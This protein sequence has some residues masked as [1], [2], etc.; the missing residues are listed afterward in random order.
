[1]KIVLI[2][3]SCKGESRRELIVKEVFK[4]DKSDQLTR[5]PTSI[6]SKEPKVIKA[7]EPE[8]GDLYVCF[9]KEA[10]IS[11]AIAKGE[12]DILNVKLKVVRNW[13]NRYSTIKRIQILHVQV[14]FLISVLFLKS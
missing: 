6:D 10:T 4:I 1:M 14:P 7:V 11:N 2:K 9:D 3:C 5:V 12:T 8:T 13:I